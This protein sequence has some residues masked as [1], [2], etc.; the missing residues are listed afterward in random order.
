M[1]KAPSDIEKREVWKSYGDRRPVRVPMRWNVNARIILLNPQLNP[2]GWTFRDYFSDPVVT[3][4]VQSRFQEYVATVLNR[5][6]DGVCELPAQWNFSVDNQNI[7]DS[8]YFGAEV[9]FAPSQV[10]VTH[11]F[12]TLDDVDAFIA[13]DFSRPLENSWIR[14]RLDFHARLTRAAS[15]FEYLGRK[16]IVHPFGVFFDGPVTVATNLFGADVFVLMAEDPGK[17]RELLMTITR[18]AIVRNRALSELA[19]GW[20]KP[21]SWGIPDDSI[22]L[23]SSEMLD[24]IVIPVHEYWLSEMSNTTVAGGRRNMHLC[25]DATRHFPL[26]HRRL[27][28][29]SFDTGFPVDHGKLRAELGPDVE[30]SGGPEVALLKDGTPSQCHDRAR[31]ILQ[32][33]I[34]AGGRFILQEG[35]NLPPCVPLANLEAVYGACQEY[36]RYPTVGGAAT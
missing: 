23:I 26:L 36:G 21:D 5:T 29:D 1:M 2:K 27:G 9:L 20:Q 3:L 31:A 35:N 12:M 25:G 32:S 14:D 19:G 16:G 18:A 6:C 13:R 22:A 17:A 24:E 10:P 15:S 7:Y 30:I 8:A 4:A 11:Q 34:M 33:G 28:I